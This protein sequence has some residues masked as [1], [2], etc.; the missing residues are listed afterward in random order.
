MSDES[1]G[2]LI[3]ASCELD[4]MRRVPFTAVKASVRPVRTCPTI[5]TASTTTLAVSETH[6]RSDV[7][8]AGAISTIPVPQVVHDAHMILVEVVAACVWYPEEQDDISRH[9]PLEKKLPSKQV[10][11]NKGMESEHAAHR[12]GPEKKMTHEI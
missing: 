7:V 4:A 6:E 9:D 3:E 11:H 8:V 2:I 5:H 1:S 10:K 12:V